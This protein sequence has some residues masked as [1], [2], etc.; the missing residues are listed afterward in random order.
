GSAALPANVVRLLETWRGGAAAAVTFERLLV[1]RTTSGD[2]LDFIFDTPAL[3]RYLGARLGA[4]AVVIRADE[5]AA[6]QTA[7]V[8]SP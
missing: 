8:R 2:T 3:R 7:L 1:L 6:L 5:W 4:M